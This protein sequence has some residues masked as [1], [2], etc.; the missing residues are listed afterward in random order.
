MLRTLIL[1]NCQSW[2]RS[3]IEDVFKIKKNALSLDKLHK[4][5]HRSVKK[6]CSLAVLL[7]G[8]LAS[9]GFNDKGSLQKLAGW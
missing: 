6:T 5:T 7:I 9:M 8:V 4:Y 2:V 3:I 1:F